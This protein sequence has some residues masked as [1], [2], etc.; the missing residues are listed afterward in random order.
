MTK[1]HP[2]ETYLLTNITS[3]TQLKLNFTLIDVPKLKNY[4]ISTHP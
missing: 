4:L 2:N 3:S 1:Q